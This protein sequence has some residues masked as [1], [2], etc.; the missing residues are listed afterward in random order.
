MSFC[1][2]PAAAQ[3]GIR[4]APAPAAQTEKS[5]PPRSDGAGEAETAE[6]AVA[7][8]S[9]RA[10]LAA[11]LEL[12]RA[13]EYAAAAAYLD[14]SAAG[15]RRGPELARRLKAV[16][17]RQ[18]WIDLD[19]V[20]AL[21]AGDRDDGL[22]GG[23]EQVATIEA[24]GGKTEPVRMV[25]RTGGWIFSRATVARIDAWYEHLP[26]RWLLEHL[27][28]PLLRH[29]P[30]DLMWWQWLALPVWIALAWAAGSLFSRSSRGLL[31]RIAARTPP[32]WDDVLIGRMGGPLTLGWG[33]AVTY[34]LL[35]WLGLYPPAQAAAHQILRA[36]FLAAFFWTLLRAV[37]V[38]GDVMGEASWARGQSAPRSL[39]PLAA[40]VG[41][42]AVVA[43]AVVALLSEL[44]YPV[45][46]LI[47]GLGIGGLALALAAQKTVENLFGAFSIG[48]DQPFREGDFVR[49]EDFVATVEKI[50]LRSTK[51][52][53]L[54]RT[55]ITIPNGKLADSRL[56]SYTARERMRL[57]CDIPLVYGTTAAQLRHILAEMEELLRAHPLIWPEAVTV[58]LKGLGESALIVE[59]MAWFQTPDWN[60]FLGIRQEMLIGFLEIIERA[61]SALAF[62]TRTLHLP[63]ELLELVRNDRPRGDSGD[64]ATSGG[65]HGHAGGR[66]ARVSENLSNNG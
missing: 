39:L 63:G 45:A 52:R 19:D 36:G 56:E 12:C 61:G 1:P 8:D 25:R 64:G 11:F 15:V 47:A 13:G 48:A 51:F 60:V 9:P 37:D 57:A 65:P 66:Q 6:E 23:V 24:T 26:D 55:L 43:V 5:E 22:R 49:I 62:P 31:L 41:K 33:L 7:S 20:S 27:P 18:V 14:L 32:R 42:I 38:A 17:D 35:P 44:G 2:A 58:K 10:A 53:T 30:A 40:R 50:G 28:A 21:P 54:D 16:L 34:L 3:F 4:G 29:G 59:V 46:S